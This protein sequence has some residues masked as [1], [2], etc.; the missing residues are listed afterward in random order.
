MLRISVVAVGEDKDRWVSE[1]AAHYEKMLSRWASVEWKIVKTAGPDSLSPAEIKKREAASL[2]RHV[3]KGLVIAL[4]DSG[5][6]Y[7]SKAFAKQLE[8]WQNRSQG[9][10]TFVIGGPYGLDQSLLDRA[11]AVLS[12]SSLT[13]SHQVV[14]L[15]LLEQLF[16][17][18]SILA[19]TSYH[20]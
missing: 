15:V 20:K 5:R 13:Y 7:E 12:L 17:A 14:R 11:D 16:R 18:L 8:S 3:G 9:Q 19:G 4:S 10:I 1:G 6:G 2:E